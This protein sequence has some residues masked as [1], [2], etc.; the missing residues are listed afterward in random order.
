MEMDHD[1]R[2]TIDYL[3][4]LPRDAVVLWASDH[5]SAKKP[6][7]TGWIDIRIAEGGPPDMGWVWTIVRSDDPDDPK[8]GQLWCFE[9]PSDLDVHSVLD[10]SEGW[11]VRELPVPA[12]EQLPSLLVAAYEENARRVDG[13]YAVREAWSTGAVNDALASWAARHAGRADLRFEWD[14]TAGPSAALAQAIDRARDGG[15]V[16]DLGDGLKV[17]DGLMDDLLALHPDD[18]AEVIP[19]L[20]EAVRDVIGGTP[21]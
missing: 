15:P 16:W 13:A 6:W 9:W 17:V 10:P 18:A 4:A 1:S 3:R 11:Y 2:V 20:R 21:S 19:A 5:V 14:R 12:G 8:P 7:A